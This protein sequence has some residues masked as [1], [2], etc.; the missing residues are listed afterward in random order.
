M[1]KASTEAMWLRKLLHETDFS[2]PS[3]PPQTNLDIEIKPILYADNQGAITLAANP[4]FHNKTKHIENQYHY[5]RE[6]LTE[7]SI[8]IKHIFTDNM[9]ADG[10]TKPLPRIR[11]QRFVHQLG[12]KETGNSKE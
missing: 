2:T 11:F 5:I 9:I 4:V 6:R 7:E 3:S 10:L 8:E 1:S 12:L